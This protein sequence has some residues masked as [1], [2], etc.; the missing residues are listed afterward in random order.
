MGKQ[1][2]KKE[3]GE[4]NP[5]YVVGLFLQGEGYTESRGLIIFNPREVF[6]PFHGERGCRPE[7]ERGIDFFLG[8]P[9]V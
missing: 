8:V 3:R 7:G 2:K 4:E 6:L 5:V 9:V 1:K